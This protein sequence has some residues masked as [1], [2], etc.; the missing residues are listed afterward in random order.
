MTT[1]S[2]IAAAFFF[3]GYFLAGR[4]WPAFVVALIVGLITGAFSVTDS[5][6]LQALRA[7]LARLR[8]ADNGGEEDESHL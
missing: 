2:I 4:Q 3:A 7:H 8:Q 6:E 5:W 1:V